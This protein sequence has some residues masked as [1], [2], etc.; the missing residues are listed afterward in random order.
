MAAAVTVV[1]VVVEVVVVAAEE[2]LLALM[3]RPWVVIAAGRPN[4]TST[5]MWNANIGHLSRNTGLYQRHSLLYPF[6]FH[7]LRQ[8]GVLG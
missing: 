6:R 3:Q 1:V 4:N 8:F 2:D 7:L 5:R